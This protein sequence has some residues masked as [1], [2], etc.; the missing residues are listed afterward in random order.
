MKNRPAVWLVSMLFTMLLFM[1]VPQPAQ[2]QDE[3]VV[4]KDTVVVWVT[5]REKGKVG[6]VKVWLP[7]VDFILYG[8][9]SQGSV[10]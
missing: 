3:F 5:W 1:P 9:T 10:F 6:R 2:A 8:P 7:Q 4:A